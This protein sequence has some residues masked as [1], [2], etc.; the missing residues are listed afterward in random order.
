MNRFLDR[1]LRESGWVTVLDP[2]IS[3][4]KGIR[5]P[6]LVIWRGD[7]AK[8]LDTTVA[9]DAHP[10]NLEVVHRRKVSYYTKRDII[11][12]EALWSGTSHIEV[13]TVAFNWRGYISAGTH[14]LLRDIHLISEI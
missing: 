5:R 11:A 6:I 8:I 13:N 1:S 10:A 12:W 4:D 3:T 7:Q 9:A 2:T 14:A